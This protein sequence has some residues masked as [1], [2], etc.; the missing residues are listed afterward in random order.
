MNVVG[1]NVPRADAVPKVTGA[2]R[3]VDDLEFPRMLHGKVIRSIHP[4][5]KI[6]RI[7]VTRALTVPDV[8]CVVTAKDI[9]NENIV[10]VVFRD[11]PAL[12][13]QDVNYVGEPIAV[14]AAENAEAARI[15]AHL[16]NVEYD[17][18]PA[19]LDIQSARAAESPK[20]YGKDNIFAYHKVRKGDVEIGFQE[21]DVIVENLYVTPYQEHAYLEPQ[22]MIAVPMPDGGMDIYGSMQCPFYVEDAVHTVLGLPLNKIRVVQTETGGAFGGKE[23]VPSLVAVQAALAAWVN[24]RP[25]KITYTRSEDI[26]SMSK[27]HPSRI[28]FKS[29]ATKEGRLTAVEVEFL[30]D[31]GA[32]STLSPVVLWRGTVHAAGPYRVPNVKVDAYAI[33][34]NKVPCGAFRGF[35]SPQVLFAAESQMDILADRLEL[36]PV[37]FRRQ[38]LL[39]TGDDTATQQ[40]LRHSVGALETLDKAVTVSDWSQK[41][42]ELVKQNGHIRKGIGISTI[43]YGAGLGAGGRHLAKTG[44]NVQIMGDG[45][46]QFAVGTTEMGQGMGTVLS[47]IVAQELGVPYQSVTMIAPD[48]SRV[49]DSGPTVASRSTMMSG[50]ALQNACAKIRKNLLLVAA[51]MLNTSPEQLSVVGEKVIQSSDEATSVPMSK[52]IREAFSRRINLAS[53]GWDISPPTSWDSDTGHGDAYV[54]YAF[55]TNIAEVSVNTLTGEIQVDRLYAA[56]DM[57]KAVNPAGVE[58]QIEGG[59]IQ[60]LG[61][62]LMEEVIMQEGVIQ[63]PKFAT[64]IIPTSLDGPEIIPIIVEEAYPEGPFG[65]KGFGEQPLMGIAPAILN[66]VAHAIGTRFYK[67]PLKPEDVLKAIASN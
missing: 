62:A 14:V 58:G 34:T 33:A 30:I 22:G 23:D 29:A 63:N 7:D 9:P 66:A 4:R 3:Y 47:Q 20:I 65:A 38:N 55:A 59:S 36:D 42:I 56:H 10:P 13:E 16:V 64:Y 61:Y 2:A 11:Q 25:V 48:T 24:K 41:R 35:G 28:H 8:E 12:A 50:R 32:Y 17:P 40:K 52:V 39:R 6:K 57:G 37:E 67:L 49:P 51:D 27:R 54:V 46:V 15:A 1:K 19:V 43:Y 45:S 21:A 26:E 53:E 44:A 31:S 18:L 5:A 60:G